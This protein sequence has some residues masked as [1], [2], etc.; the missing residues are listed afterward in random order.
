MAI[1]RA[2]YRPLALPSGAGHDAMALADL[3]NVGMI[4]VRCRGGVSHHPDEHVSIEDADIGA[5]VLLDVIEHFQP[6]H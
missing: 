2:G 4:F 5:R 1:E 6:W 3:T